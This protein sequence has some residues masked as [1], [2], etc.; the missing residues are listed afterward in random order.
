[1]HV[2]LIAT[3]LWALFAPLGWWGRGGNRVRSLG[4]LCCLGVF[5]WFT[6]GSPSVV[7]A[8]LMF[9]VWSL[10]Q[11][12]RRRTSKIN[13]LAATAAVM[14]L[15]R[16]LWLFDVGFQLSFAAVLGILTLY[17]WLNGWVVCRSSLGRWLVSFFSVT[18]SA[19]LATAPLVLYYFSTF[20]L[21]FWVGNAWGIPL[22]T[23]L[24]MGVVPLVLL[25]PFP[26]LQIG[27]A[28]LLQGVIEWLQWG[29]EWV[30]RLPHAA[31]DTPWVGAVDVVCLY[32]VLISL[33]WLVRYREWDACRLLLV[34]VLIGG[35]HRLIDQARHRPQRSLICY[36]QSPHPLVHCVEADG[37]SYLA[38]ADSVPVVETIRTQAR[39]YWLHRRL[40]SPQTVP[41][42]H[43]QGALAH[44]EGF[45]SFHGCRFQILTGG[46]WR[47]REATIPYEVH[48][49][50]LFKT[51]REKLADALRCFRPRVVLLDGRL[52]AGH[53]QRLESECQAHSIPY[54]IVSGKGSFL[55]LL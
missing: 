14:L 48:Y 42:H 36:P 55:L 11:L 54:K 19:Q 49:L 47:G 37:R 43:Y 29:V 23:V 18:V 1:M 51:Y 10:A 33:V 8:V 7:R 35:G 46:G 12:F 4:V 25:F 30:A 41:M 17:P 26:S 22:I 50:Y 28:T 39:R 38:Y 32:L 40:P 27:V 44:Y 52:S 3:C 15:Y 2:G 16:P 53:L 6:G 34:A 45:V 21:Y 31:L 9:S 5:A 20:P 24:L 13:L